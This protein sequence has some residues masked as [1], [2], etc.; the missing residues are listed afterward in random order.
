MDWARQF[1][2][3]C[4]RAD[5]TFWSEPI[6]AVTNIAFLIAAAIVWYRLAGLRLPI[7]RALAVMLTCCGVGSFLFHTF[8]TAWASTLDVL[9]ILAF[10]LIYIFA[11]NRHYWNL[12]LWPA[13]GVTVLFIPYAAA[14][15]PLFNMIPWI[16]PS[17]GYAPVPLLILIYAF[18]LR[19]RM[20]QTARGLTVGA[21]ILI[22]SLTFRTLDDPICSVFPVGTHFMWHILNATMLAW[23]IDVY[24]KHMIATGRA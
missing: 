5:L 2:A 7:A 1:D 20:P 19:Q 9:P 15:V 3:Y 24:K 22:M 14:T 16:A 18:L 6:N 13:I 10:I 8:A 23:M 12:G 21:G 4:E 17:A 11:A